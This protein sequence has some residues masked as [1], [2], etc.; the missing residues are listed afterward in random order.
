MD[1][2][3]INISKQTIVEFSETILTILL[4]IFF[5]LL[6]I[7]NLFSFVATNFNKNDQTKL[8]YYY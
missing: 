4:N 6:F 2:I 3:S 5:F 7:E 1:Y 8:N